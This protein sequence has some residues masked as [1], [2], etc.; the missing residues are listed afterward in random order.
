MCQ[1]AP[2]RCASR[3]ATE[4]RPVGW[5][6]QLAQP[7]R[8][9]DAP[10][11]ATYPVGQEQVSACGPRRGGA[12]SSHLRPSSWE[13][14]RWGSVE[15]YVVTSASIRRPLAR[16][17]GPGAAAR[18]SGGQSLRPQCQ[19]GRFGPRAARGALSQ[20]S[21]A[22]PLASSIL[23]AQAGVYLGLHAVFPLYVSVLWAAFLLSKG[24]P[25]TVRVPLHDL[26]LT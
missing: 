6:S 12:G 19:H 1:Q 5:K 8:E 7:P 11:P 2:S 20:A 10:P 17:Q 4:R 26:V 15:S 13:W 18:G 9:N 25:A 24:T 16:Q 3:K 22:W 23:G 21:P 14:R